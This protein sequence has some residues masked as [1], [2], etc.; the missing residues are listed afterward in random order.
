MNNNQ[1]KL[2]KELAEDFAP[3]V[4]DIESG[5][6]TTQNNYGRYGAMLSKLSKGN[7][8]V[9]NILGLAMIEAGANANGVNDALAVFFPA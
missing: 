7:R 3:F 9:A 8:K 6:A 2:I 5:I 4:Q 1:K